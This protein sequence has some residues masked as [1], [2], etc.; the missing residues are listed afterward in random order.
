ML[1]GAKA[2][3]VQPD[4]AFIAPLVFAADSNWGGRQHVRSAGRPTGGI[5]LPLLSWDLLIVLSRPIICGTI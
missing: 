3:Q 5:G 2:M 1:S 4:A